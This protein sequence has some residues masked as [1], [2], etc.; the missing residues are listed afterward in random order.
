MRSLEGAVRRVGFEPRVTARPEDLEAAD[1]LILGGVGAFGDGMA[2]LRQRGLEEVMAR[3]V[4]EQEKP[5]LG[6][7][8]GAQLMARG[9]SEFGQHEGLGWI[10]ATVERLA[11]RGNQFR[12]PHVGWNDLFQRAPS[13]LTKGIPEESLFYYVH[14]YHICCAD[15]RI[16]VGVCE[17]GHVF[18]AAFQQAA[19]YGTQFHPEKS[20]QHGL[21]LLENFLR[22]GM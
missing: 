22:L 18:T 13:P 15:E 16:V 21:A 11:P 7:C 8:L 4:V 10:D 9:S 6:I 3:L 12:V 2:N 17:H 19:I 1:K 14:S 20:Q 5:I